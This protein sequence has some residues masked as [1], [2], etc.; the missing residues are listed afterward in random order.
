M[1][2]SKKM[3]QML[4]TG[5]S[6][7]LLNSNVNAQKPSKEVINIVLVHGAFADG[8]SWAK[9][10]KILQH[11]GF[12]VIAVQ[13][14]LTSLNDDVA[15]T[16]RVIEAMDGP[17][18]LCG[19]SSAGMVITEA[20]NNPKVVGLLYASALIPDDGQ[21]VLDVIKGYPSA[22]GDAETREDSPGF[23]TLSLKGIEQNFVQDLSPSERKI[24]YAT[25][26]PWGKAFLTQKIGQAAW[27][28]KPS[29]CIIASD[30]RSVN[31]DL[32]RKE[33]KMINATILE[34]K[35]AH[36]S[37]LSHPKEVSEFIIKA[38]RALSAG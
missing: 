29:W 33:A 6:F 26:G 21:N 28:T 25:Q 22:G 14:P 7:F 11:K 15:A 27:K 9:V 2:T 37:M 18:L 32:E 13:N 12:N 4:I 10:I 5:L 3:M 24:V 20:G 17:V 1:S 30:D 34:L 35:S 38:A 31:P 19:H 16:N 8:S 23:L 36:V